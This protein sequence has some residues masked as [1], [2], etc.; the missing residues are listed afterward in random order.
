MTESALLRNLPA[1]RLPMIWRL[2]CDPALGDH[3]PSSAGEITNMDQTAMSHTGNSP[4][5]GMAA[6]ALADGSLFRGHGIGAHGTA[7]GE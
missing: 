6:L 2:T 4:G 1:R 7:I 3:A 5:A